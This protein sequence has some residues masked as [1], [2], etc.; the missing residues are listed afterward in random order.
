[1]FLDIRIIHYQA[2]FFRKSVHASCIV[3][4]EA[5]IIHWLAFCL[6]TVTIN[7]TSVLVAT[8]SSN[9]PRVSNEVIE[10]LFSNSAYWAIDHIVSSSQESARYKV[11]WCLL[12]QLSHSGQ[13]CFRQCSNLTFWHHLTNWCTNSIERN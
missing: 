13:L 11:L 7:F 3:L 6:E 5:M 2:I 10:L 1:M 9:A 12:R 4:L 8:T